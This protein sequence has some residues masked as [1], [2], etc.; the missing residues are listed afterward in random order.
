MTTNRP[1][2][3]NMVPTIPSAALPQTPVSEWAE[4]MTD[5]LG[6]HMTRTPIGTPG[7]DVPG[8]YPSHTEPDIESVTSSMKAETPGF[9]KRTPAKEA[10]LLETAQAT[11]AAAT[12]Y[13]PQSVAAYLPTT[14]DSPANFASQSSLPPL[15]PSSTSNSSSAMSDSTLPEA[16][17][18]QSSAHAHHASTG[19]S[20][21]Y[22]TTVHTGHSSTS[23][24]P[25]ALPRPT[26]GL[27]PSHPGAVVPDSHTNVSS[28]LVDSPSAL[29]PKSS[30][31]L[32]LKAQHLPG[33]SDTAAQAPPEPTS[34]LLPSH[35]GVAPSNNSSTTPHAPPRPTSGLLP[36]H[37]GV[38]DNN[39]ESET[40]N[41][42]A[43]PAPHVTH[44]PTHIA[45]RLGP[46]S[47]PHAVPVSAA[48]PNA[49][50][51]R[52]AL[53]SSA[54]GT[55]SDAATPDV[56]EMSTPSLVPSASIDSGYAASTESET[57]SLLSTPRDEKGDSDSALFT[58]VPAPAVPVGAGGPGGFAIRPQ[59]SAALNSSRPEDNLPIS[60]S[61]PSSRNA[62]Q[63]QTHIDHPRVAPALGQG[64][65]LL[66]AEVQ[67]LD[68]PP[69][70]QTMRSVSTG[71]V[72]DDE[73]QGV[74]GEGEEDGEGEGEGEGGEGSGKGKG[75]K[76][77]LIQRLKEKIV[78]GNGT[79]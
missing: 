10:T 4:N 62:E 41:V 68:V 19:E 3:P 18:T 38:N 1:S 11:L 33:A 6:S 66:A 16:Q 39:P 8:G 27:V 71:Q 40:I 51:N 37:P 50:D 2:E 28:P 63:A 23:I 14:A 67:G 34:G 74:D 52:A 65:A 26:S 60:D 59:G 32:A 7:P 72:A 36:S 31:D 73:G 57:P 55:R 30:T 42:S 22:S 70:M 69:P 77:K 49:G 29:S 21:A 78:G 35:P 45:H 15:P 47:H 25:S 58:P 24:A 64:Q 44:L 5:M 9:D 20:V 12:A 56:A 75:K 46:H 54:N 79:A 17:R 53:P 13:L 43:D 48:S 76:R 61:L